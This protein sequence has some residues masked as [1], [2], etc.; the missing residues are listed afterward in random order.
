MGKSLDR[1]AKIFL[2]IGVIVV[3]AVA[4]WAGRV[5]DFIN[6]ASLAAGQVIDLDR[7]HS[8]DSTS[9]YPIVKF[10]TRAGQVRT[11]RNPVGSNP[12]S[13]RVGETVEVLYDEAQPSDARIRSFFSLWGGPTIVGGCG[14]LLVLAGGGILYARRRAARRIQELRRHGTPVQTDFQNVEQNM[15]VKVNGRSPWRIVSQW[16]NPNTG[17]LHLF[18]SENLWFDPTAHLAARRITVYLDRLNPKRYYMDVS[19]LPKLPNSFVP[20]LR[21]RRNSLLF[22]RS[23]WLG[24][25]ELHVG[26]VLH[27]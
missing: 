20:R 16:K 10:E 1:W 9:Y 12:P 15:R 11:F 3:A 4:Y 21:R 19:F 18:E 17:E 26:T 8:G 22:C 27:S 13:F 23:L 14:A 7:S 24:C 25:A 5:H 2:V 6:R